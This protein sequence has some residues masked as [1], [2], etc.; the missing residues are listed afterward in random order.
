M[1]IHTRKA[2]CQ[3]FATVLSPLVIL[4]ILAKDCLTPPPFFFVKLFSIGPGLGGHS[5]SSIQPWT[6]AHIM[7]LKLMGTDGVRACT[8]IL[9]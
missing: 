6:S 1:I 7:T 8:M 2:S 4:N 3:P 5:P 9:L